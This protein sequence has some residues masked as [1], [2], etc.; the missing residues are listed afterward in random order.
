MAVLKINWP[1]RIAIF[2]VAAFIAGGL[3]RL[4]YQL[5]SDKQVLEGFL[6]ESAYLEFVIGELAKIQ[7]TRIVD[8]HG[9]EDTRPYKDYL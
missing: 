1:R 8:F 4:R 7:I 6:W 5:D 2:I 3:F 9:T